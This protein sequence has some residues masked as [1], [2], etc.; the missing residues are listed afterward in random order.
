M[1]MTT[2]LQ[3]EGIITNNKYIHKQLIYI[4]KCHHHC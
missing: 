3:L 1:F 4:E 2:V